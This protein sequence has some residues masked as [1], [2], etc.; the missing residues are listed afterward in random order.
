MSQCG[1]DFGAGV[2][3]SCGVVVGLLVAAKQMYNTQREDGKEKET[4]EERYSETANRTTI[5]EHP[6]IEEKMWD[7]LVPI[8]QVFHESPNRLLPVR[9]KTSSTSCSYHQ[10][11]DKQSISKHQ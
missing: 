4:V 6:R 2:V 7:C 10:I 11:T 3:E 9:I 5:L 8:L 1:V